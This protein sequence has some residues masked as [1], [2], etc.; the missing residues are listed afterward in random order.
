ML[1]SA[2]E[3]VALAK[4]VPVSGVLDEWLTEL[5]AQMVGTLKSQ[6]LESTKNPKL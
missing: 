3:S 5:E 1:S 2:G 6:L 4:P